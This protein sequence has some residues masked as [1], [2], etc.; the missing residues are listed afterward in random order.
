M[1]LSSGRKKSESATK[2]D[3]QHYRTRARETAPARGLGGEM[4]HH[5]EPRYPWGDKS[6]E[7]MAAEKEERK[8]QLAEIAE[9]QENHSDAT[10]AM[11]TE[12]VRMYREI[13]DMKI[14]PEWLART[15]KI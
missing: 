14:N 3:D 2:K 12:F 4:S 6:L 1:S 15:W 10:K 5:D 7:Q 9:L 8:R 13:Q 11:F